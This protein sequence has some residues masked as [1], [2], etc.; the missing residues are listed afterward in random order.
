MSDLTQ[1]IINLEN[2]LNAEE[3]ARLTRD[4]GA[5]WPYRLI[6]DYLTKIENIL[7]LAR[8][9][10]EN[11]DQTSFLFG[12]QGATD[13]TALSNSRRVDNARGEGVQ[14][15]RGRRDE[16]DIYGEPTTRRN[17]DTGHLGTQATRDKELSTEFSMPGRV[18][19]LSIDDLTVESIISGSISANANAT[20]A[21]TVAQLELKDKAGTIYYL[22]LYG[23]P[24]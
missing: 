18:K 6:E 13:Q 14:L 7:R 23:A 10:D 5:Q 3:I 1:A 24:W 9:L 19:R 2:D 11:N 8:S 21:N 22:P 15:V 16:Q 17:I 20:P 4:A 12:Q